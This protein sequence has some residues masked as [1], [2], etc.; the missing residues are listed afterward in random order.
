[1][2]EKETKG[3]RSILKDMVISR[4][5]LVYLVS[6]E[7]RRV[8]SEI[9]SLAA[10]FKP[11]FRTYV[12]S[13]TTGV[14]LDDEMVLPKPGIL[15]ALD[16]FMNI[17]EAAFLLV[18]DVHVFTKGNPPVI[19]KL[20]DVAKRIDNEYKTIFLL[21]PVLEVPP[22]M[23]SDVVL[24]DVPLPSTD[25]VERLLQQVVSKEKDPRKSPG[26]VDRRGPRFVHQSRSGAF[27]SA[28]GPGVSEDLGWPA[29]GL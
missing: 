6:D 25:E 2:A 4:T 28:S 27:Q 10:A 14:T 26:I 20:K 13:C 24:V 19:R 17:K 9:R 11:P 5:S 15:D 18:Q 3:L 21:S 22:E 1:M 7:D 16:W 23:S 29:N 12:W 8:E